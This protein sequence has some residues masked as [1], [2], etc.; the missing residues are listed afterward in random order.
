MVLAIIFGIGGFFG[1]L[2]YACCCAAGRCSRYEEMNAYHIRK[3]M[4]SE[5]EDT[6]VVE[7]KEDVI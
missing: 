1:F 3:N 5:V 6:S 2:A 7:R 4:E